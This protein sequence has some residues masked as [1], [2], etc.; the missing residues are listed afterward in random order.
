MNGLKTGMITFLGPLKSD[1]EVYVLIHILDQNIS[2][3]DNPETGIYFVK[4]T[5]VVSVVEKKKKDNFF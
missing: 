4:Y 1:F 3:K 5:L 2:N